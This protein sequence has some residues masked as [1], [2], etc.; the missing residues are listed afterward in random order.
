MH[1]FLIES[2]LGLRIRAGVLQITPHLPAGWPGYRVDYLHGNTRYSIEV[3]R[4]EGEGAA[5]VP[6]RIALS[7]DGV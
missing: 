1:R 7:D 5:P 4:A 6:T 3:F 2:L